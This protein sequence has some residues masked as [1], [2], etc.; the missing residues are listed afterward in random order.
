M[1][2]LGFFLFNLTKYHLIIIT[3]IHNTLISKLILLVFVKIYWRVLSYYFVKTYGKFQVLYKVKIKIL[4]C[5]FKLFLFFRLIGIWLRN[6]K[7]YMKVFII[8]KNKIKKRIELIKYVEYKILCSC[9]RYETR[10]II[11][12]KTN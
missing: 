6:H 4:V 8:K 5:R 3:N 1:K 12:S 2:K 7:I 11:K 9:I 10:R